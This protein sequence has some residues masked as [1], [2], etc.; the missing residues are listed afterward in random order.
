MEVN[1]DQQL[2]S[3]QHSMDMNSWWSQFCSI[4]CWKPK[5][6]L[7]PLTWN[8]KKVKMDQQ[9]L[10]VPIDPYTVVWNTMQVNGDQQLFGYQHSMEVNSCWFPFCNVEYC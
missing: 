1:R 4:E 3:Y 7:S 2:F 6:W 8:T 9:Q 10:L 5:S